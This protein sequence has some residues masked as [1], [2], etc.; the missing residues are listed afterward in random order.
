LLSHAIALVPALERA[1]L[2]GTWSS[3]RPYTRD[4]LPLLGPSQ[5]E[6]LTL[7][8]G[9]YRNGILLAP[10]SAEIVRAAVLGQRAPIASAA[11]AAFRPERE[12]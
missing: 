9:H 5:I 11:L 2:R 7:A 3:F 12:P 8:T 6:G 10:I 1:S 4:H